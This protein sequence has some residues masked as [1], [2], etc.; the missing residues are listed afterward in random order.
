MVTVTLLN[1]L[2]LYK[3]KSE[4]ISDPEIITSFPGRKPSSSTA[5]MPNSATFALH[6]VTTK[7]EEKEN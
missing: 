3:K 7:S 2:L 4:E 1:H 6:G 5:F